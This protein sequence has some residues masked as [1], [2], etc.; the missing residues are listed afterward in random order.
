MK[1][2]QMRIRQLGWDRPME[3]IAEM[4]SDRR[5]IDFARQRLTEQ[6]RILDIEVWSGLTQLC[7]LQR[8]GAQAQAA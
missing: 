7:R 6:P 3:L 5:A 2:Y 8:G 1:T 4:R